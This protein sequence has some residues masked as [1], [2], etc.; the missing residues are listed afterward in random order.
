MNMRIVYAHISAG[1]HCSVHVA[2]LWFPRLPVS[3]VLVTPY[4]PQG[5]ALVQETLSSF[6][7]FSTYSG[8]HRVQ[9]PQGG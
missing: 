8:N 9:L 3:F 4:M 2:D 6:I 5:S 1:I 7:A